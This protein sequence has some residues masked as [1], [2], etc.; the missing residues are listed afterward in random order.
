MSDG[1]I[2]SPFFQDFQCLVNIIF[3]LLIILTARLLLVKV[4]E[5]RI[6]QVVFAQYTTKY[7]NM[8]RQ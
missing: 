8:V 4:K 7:N 5:S 3:Y 6:E 2:Y 1:H